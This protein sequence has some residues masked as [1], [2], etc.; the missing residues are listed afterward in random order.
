MGE[1][2]GIRGQSSIWGIIHRKP[3]DRVRRLTVSLRRIA[4]AS[5]TF[6]Q[7]KERLFF[8]FPRFDTQLD[9]LYQDAVVTQTLHLGHA[10]YLFGNRSGKGDAA[11]AVLCRGHGII[12]HQCGAL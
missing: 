2:A 9:E 4:G 1:A 6:G 11:A 8:L 3:D 5:K 10:V 12:V 7:L